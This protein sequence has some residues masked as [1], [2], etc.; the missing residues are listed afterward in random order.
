MIKFATV[1]TATDQLGRSLHS[2]TRSM[3]PQTVRFMGPLLR[4]MKYEF[5]CESDGSHTALH[6]DANSSE[7]ILF[8]EDYSRELT[9]GPHPI[10]LS[11]ASPLLFAISIYFPEKPP[12]II[13]LT[14]LQL[15]PS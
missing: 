12:S 14:P 9:T 8:Y 4:L 10:P 13:P 7:E 1:S 11:F 3:R 6:S 15:H 5:Q 2:L